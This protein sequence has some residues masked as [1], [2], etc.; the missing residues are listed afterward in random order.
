MTVTMGLIR[1]YSYRHNLCNLTNWLKNI[2]YR[3]TEETQNDNDLEM[4]FDHC[5]NRR[6][7]IDSTVSIEGNVFKSKIK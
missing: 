6:D 5:M 7:S 3:Y 1:F 2:L 4:M